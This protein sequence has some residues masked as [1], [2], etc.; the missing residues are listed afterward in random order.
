MDIAASHLDHQATLVV[1]SDFLLMDREPGPVL[2]RLAG[3]PGQVHAV[4]LGRRLPAGVLD[5]RI[6]VAHIDRESCPGAVARALFSSL[7][8]HRPGSRVAGEP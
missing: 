6:A 1:F 3:F 2:S 7:V 4:V 8:A 5:E